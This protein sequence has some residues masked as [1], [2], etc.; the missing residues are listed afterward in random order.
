MKNAHVSPKE[1]S[2]QEWYNENVADER[3][4]II[5]QNGNDGQHY[6]QSTKDRIL[7]ETPESVK[8]QV[9]ETADKLISKQET[10]EKAFKFWSDRQT[11]YDKLDILRF[12]A[13]WQQERMYSEE[14]VLVILHKR[15]MYKWEDHT[16]ILSM[17][18]WFEQ[19]K[20]K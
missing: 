10:L 1:K 18:Q 14:E 20:R 17:T 11:S 15:D 19:H 16:K 2:S 3:M 5:G 12:G 6:K 4:N 7:S 9:R 13:L 8:Q